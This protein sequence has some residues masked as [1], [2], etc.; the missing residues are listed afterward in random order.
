MINTLNLK[1]KISAV[2][3]NMER[4]KDSVKEITEREKI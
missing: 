4:E 2:K 1:K 3:S